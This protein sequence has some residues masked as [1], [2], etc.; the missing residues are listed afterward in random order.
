MVP[1]WSAGRIALLGDAASAV[2]LIAGKGA[3]LAMAGA[4]VL[5]DALAE[6]RGGPKAAFAAYEARLRPRA[7]AAQ[8]MARRHA[9]LF[10]TADR[11]QLLAREA[12]LRPAARPFLAPVVRRLLSHK[13]EQLWTRGRFARRRHPS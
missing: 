10:T 6:Y 1:R 3:T 7:E 2:S 12:V 5:A 13:G 4:V 9:R 8:R 11:S